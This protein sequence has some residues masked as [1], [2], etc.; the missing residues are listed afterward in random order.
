[1]QAPWDTTNPYAAMANNPVYFE[2]PD[3]ENPVAGVATFAG[4]LWADVTRM[5][6]QA[7]RGQT[8]EL[9]KMSSLKYVAGRISVAG[10]RGI[11]A[12]LGGASTIA[13]SAGVEGAASAARQFGA[14]GRVDGRQLAVDAAL[15][16]ASSGLGSLVK[17]SAPASHH[18]LTNSILAGR[19]E[20]TGEA[21]Y[22]YGRLQGWSRP[23][24]VPVNSASLRAPT[25]P[26]S[27]LCAPPPDGRRL[28]P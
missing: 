25:A 15:G 13:A 9:M 19:G 11:A 16:A 6:F 5:G 7:A 14:I 22:Q 17:A 8:H 21:A 18:A 26:S 20:L 12:S 1:M 10:A 28:D 3:G 27:Y 24:P 2:D 23:A 4:S